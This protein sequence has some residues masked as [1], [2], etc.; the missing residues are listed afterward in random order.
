MTD[1]TALTA[2]ES[3]A[4]ERIGP[5]F[6]NFVRQNNPSGGE[7]DQTN[8]ADFLAYVMHWAKVQGIDFEAALST[9]Q[10]HFAFETE[11]EDDDVDEDD[12]DGDEKGDRE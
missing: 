3:K 10:M 6:E 9:A 4:I 5:L 8:L 11:D 7:D 12:E 1:D 2:R